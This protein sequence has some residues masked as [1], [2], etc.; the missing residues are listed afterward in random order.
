[1]IFDHPYNAEY[2]LRTGVDQRRI[3]AIE[4]AAKILERDERYLAV[5]RG[6][7]P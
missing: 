1:M 3:P 4:V 6:F 7:R 2:L 5:L